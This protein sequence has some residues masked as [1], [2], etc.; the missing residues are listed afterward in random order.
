MNLYPAG[1]GVEQALSFFEAEEAVHPLDGT[2]GSTFHEIV[3]DASR[4][5]LSALDSDPDLAAI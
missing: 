1:S 4:D 2:S 3:D 5:E